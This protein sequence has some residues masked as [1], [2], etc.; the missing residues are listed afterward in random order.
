MTWYRYNDNKKWVFIETTSEV[1]ARAIAIENGEVP[2]W[3]DDD[4]VYFYSLP[5]NDA[6][7]EV[8][9]R[10]E[11]MHTIDLKG[12]GK[13]EDYDGKP[14]PAHVYP[15]TGEYYVAWQDGYIFVNEAVYGGENGYGVRVWSSSVSNPF[16]VNA[17]GWD[18]TG[19]QSVPAH[20]KP[21]GYGG[22]GKVTPLGAGFMYTYGKDY[23]ACWFPTLGQAKAFRASVHKWQAAQPKFNPHHHIDMEGSS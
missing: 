9:E 18:K 20:G 15:A 23:W 5:T 6:V 7:S 1:M 17:G 19:N 13:A 11:R 14:F 22:S 21:G 10:G 16:A 3:A 4:E 8:P 12:V 2:S